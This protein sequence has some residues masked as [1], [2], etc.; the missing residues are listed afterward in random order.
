MNYF[1]KPGIRVKIVNGLMKGEAGEVKALIDGAPL[2]EK[3]Y[4]VLIDSHNLNMPMTIPS[5]DMEFETY[6]EEI[7]NFLPNEALIAYR[8]K[9]PYKYTEDSMIG[10][11]VYPYYNERYD[12]WHKIS[13]YHEYTIEED[14]TLMDN[15]MGCDEYSDGDG[16]IYE[17]V[18]VLNVRNYEL[19]QKRFFDCNM[20][21]KAWTEYL[22]WIA[23]TGKDPLDQLLGLSRSESCKYSFKFYIEGKY[24]VLDSVIN[25]DKNIV[26]T[27]NLDNYIETESDKK[28]PKSSRLPKSVRFFWQIKTVKGKW[29][30]WVAEADENKKRKLWTPEEILTADNVEWKHNPDDF[31]KIGITTL[32]IKRTAREQQRYIKQRAKELVEMGDSCFKIPQS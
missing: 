14:G 15:I 1:V 31:Y 32:G 26:Y 5:D 3:R 24:L 30:V 10:E 8:N 28:H 27:K 9:Q 18:D 2:D 11:N 12:T 13:Y 25:L 7:L 6:A 19:V 17:S 4:D 16:D 29:V 22:H 20:I 21:D 23:K